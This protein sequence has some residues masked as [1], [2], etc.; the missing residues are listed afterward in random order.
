MG[1]DTTDNPASSSCTGVSKS[2]GAVQALCDVDF[3]VRAG[4][5]MALVGDN[6][7]GKSTL[8]K[9]IAGHL[10]ARRGRDPLRRRAGRDPRPEGRRATSASRSSTRTSR[11]RDNLDVVAEHVPRPR[12][13]DRGVV[14]D[15]A[16]HGAP[17]PRDAR[18]ASRSR[19]SARCGARGRPLRRP[20]P[21]GRRREGG[22]VELQARDPRRADRR[23]RRRP[24]A[25]GARPR[26]SASP[27]RG[28]ASS[29]SR[30]TCTTSSRSPTASPCCASASSVAEFAARRPTSRRSS[31]RSPPV[32]L[33]TVPGMEDRTHEHVH[34]TARG[35][36]RCRRAAR[37]SRP[38]SAATWTDL[39]SGELGALPIILGLIV[40]AVFFQSQNS[41]FLTDRNLVNL[42]VQMAGITTIAIGV[43]FV[44][45]LG[46]ID[47]S[48]GY[49]SGRRGRPDDRAAARLVGH[50]VGRRCGDPRLLVAARHRPRPSASSSRSSASRRSSSPSP[51][52]L[53][54]NGVVLLIIGQGGTVIIQ[55]DVIIGIANNFL[56]DTGAGSSR[57]AWS[58]PGPR[59]RR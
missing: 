24:D 46:E 40:I 7:A 8:I 41:N 58:R 2:F 31:R 34:G 37:R 50:V 45:L 23:P 6:G 28:S 27:S 36:P 39:R 3:E 42:I 5:V 20:A 19:R 9:A 26:A 53:G 43:V 30:T 14:L 32:R 12:A 18:L 17:A 16:E 52:F 21:V 10:P 56:A 29:S 33:S 44:L 35:P 13:P 22:H 15:E 47:L 57:S 4:E 55:D 59:P 25:P 48:I 54:L 11:S 1:N 49:V 51:A 38:T